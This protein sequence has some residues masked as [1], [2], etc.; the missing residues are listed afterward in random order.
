MKPEL[1]KMLERQAQWQA[2]RQSESW[3]RKLEKSAAA[4]DAIYGMITHGQKHKKRP[5][6]RYPES[7]TQGQ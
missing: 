5:R 4:R 7:D 6:A 1:K 3:I 2:N